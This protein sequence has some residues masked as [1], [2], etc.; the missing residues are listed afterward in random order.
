MKSRSSEWNDENLKKNIGLEIAKIET[1]KGEKRRCGYKSIGWFLT[2]TIK[3][4]L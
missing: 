4:S 3:I 2:R 1:Q